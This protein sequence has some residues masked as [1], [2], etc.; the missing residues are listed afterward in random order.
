MRTVAD[1]AR[2]LAENRRY[3]DE[4]EA[5]TYDQRFGIA[6]D[7]ESC[8]EMVEE[9]EYVLGDRLPEGGTLVDVGCGT[10]NVSIKLARSRRFTLVYGLDISPRMLQRARDNARSVGCQA[11]FLETDMRRLPLGD[12]T[13]DLVVGCAVL[14]HLPDPHGFM[15]EVFRVLKPGGQCVFIGEPGTWGTYRTTLLKMP[16]IALNKIRRLMTGSKAQW[17]DNV[18]VHTF[19]LK[20]IETLT[21]TFDQ[22]RIRPEGF[23]VALDDV[24]LSLAREL[25]GRFPGV[26][27]A[28]MFVRRCL[29]VIDRHVFNRILPAGQLATVKFAATRPATP[30]EPIGHA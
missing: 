20:D 25:V 1:E 17:N 29:L 30:A 24:Y 9:L 11:E 15:V 19:T 5:D 10:G 23:A 7:D 2:V 26:V 13:V 16:M 27:P 8:R 18:D 14:H 21:Q 4:V 6:A 22:V 12:S 3:H 28:T